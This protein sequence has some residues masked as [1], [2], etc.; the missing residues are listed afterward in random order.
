MVQDCSKSLSRLGPPRKA[1]YSIS[2][3]LSSSM[4]ARSICVQRPAALFHQCWVTHRTETYRCGPASKAKTAITDRQCR[5][6]APLHPAEARV[7]WRRPRQP[8][9]AIPIK[10][11]R[12]LASPNPLPSE[13]IAANWSRNQVSTRSPRPHRPT[14]FRPGTAGRA[15]AEHLRQSRD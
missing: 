2:R 4:P 6:D 15:I 8:L 14:R 5:P 12:P 3:N 7:L 11:I 10:G 1:V 9:S 13:K